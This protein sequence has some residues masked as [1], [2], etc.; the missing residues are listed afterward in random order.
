MAAAVATD[1]QQPAGQPAHDARQP[2][3]HA[4]AQ[5]AFEHDL[6]HQDEQ[7]N[8]GKRKAV[9][10]APRAQPEAAQAIPAGVQHDIEAGGQKDRERNP[11]ARQQ[12]D[13]EHCDHQH[14]LGH[15]THDAGS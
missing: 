2:A 3:V 9:H 5:P 13:Q 14:E 4:L 10:A 7:R 1:E 8:G 6:G 11:H 15:F 12:Q